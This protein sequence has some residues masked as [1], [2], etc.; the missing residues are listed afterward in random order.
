MENDRPITGPVFII[1]WVLA[2]GIFKT[3]RDGMMVKSDGSLY[4]PGRYGSSFLRSSEWA[5]TEE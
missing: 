5:S 1:R 3:S 4:V 2:Q